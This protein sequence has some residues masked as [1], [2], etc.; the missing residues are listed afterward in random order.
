[1]CW[2]GAGF[3][4]GTIIEPTLLLPALIVSSLKVSISDIF[5]IPHY[6]QAPDPKKLFRNIDPVRLKVPDPPPLN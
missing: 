1:M 2:G 6:D 4:P 3:E 5:K